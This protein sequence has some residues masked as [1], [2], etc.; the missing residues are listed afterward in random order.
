[1]VAMVATPNVVTDNSWY[2]DFGATNH[3]TSD[4]NNLIIRDIYAE[5]T[6][7]IWEMVLVLQ[8]NTLQDHWKATMAEEYSALVKNKTWSLVPLPPK[9]KAIGCKWVFKVKENPDGN[10]LK[11]KARLIAKGFL[12]LAGFD[13]IETF[14]PI[15][16]PTTIRIVLTIVFVCC[17]L[18]VIGSSKVEIQ[19]LVQQ[20]NTRFALKDLG[21][22]DFFLGIQL[23]HIANGFCDVDWASNPDDRRSTTDFC[24]YLG[25]NMMS[26]NSKKQNT[27]SRSSTKAEYRILA[28]LATEVTWILSLLMITTQ[29]CYFVACN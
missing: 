15:A 29:K 9:R 4:P 28:T 21:E 14:S 25:S 8:F 18:L 11:H 22:V 2:P 10:I 12:Q 1:M 3:C 24:V 16:K 20:L 26:W 23:K 6:K 5:M 27:V 7:F 19:A 17:D 13:F